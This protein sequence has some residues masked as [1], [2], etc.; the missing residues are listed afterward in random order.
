M[1]QTTHYKL[2]LYISGG[3]FQNE[4][5]LSFVIEIKGRPNVGFTGSA[6]ALHC[7]KTH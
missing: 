4:N 7:C 3:R 5:L 2:S 6:V 1:K